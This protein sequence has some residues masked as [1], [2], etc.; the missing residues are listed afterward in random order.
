MFVVV[1]R[2]ASHIKDLLIA[3]SIA[4]VMQLSCYKLYLLRLLILLV[5]LHTY[6]PC[7]FLIGRSPSTALL[8]FLGGGFPY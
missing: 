4:C 1:L 8:P 5:S 6:R 7:G 3:F 2:W